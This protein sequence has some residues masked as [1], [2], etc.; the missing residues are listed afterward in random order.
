MVIKAGT[1]PAFTE[2]PVN[3]EIANKIM[4]VIKMLGATHTRAVGRDLEVESLVSI[5]GEAFL[6][7]SH[8]SCD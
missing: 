7:M 8:I 1:V 6:R 5:T 2:L 3:E 4:A